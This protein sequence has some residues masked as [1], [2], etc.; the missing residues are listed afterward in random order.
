ME[1]NKRLDADVEVAMK[2]ESDKG[3]RSGLSRGVSNMKFVF[4][5][6]LGVGCDPEKKRESASALQALILVLVSKL[7]SP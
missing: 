1:E 3:P 4:K 2:R 7:P 6:D 5:C